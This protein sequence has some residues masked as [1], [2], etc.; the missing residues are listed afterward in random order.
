[1]FAKASQVVPDYRQRKNPTR[2]STLSSQQPQRNPGSILLKT[3]NQNVS[4]SS[5]NNQNQLD[6]YKTAT[7]QTH[8]FSSWSYTSDREQ[9]QQQVESLLE[10]RG[11]H[12][13][14]PIGGTNNHLVLI[15]DDL[16]LPD[17][18]EFSTSSALSFLRQLISLKSL[19]DKERLLREIS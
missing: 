17:V 7:T 8:W 19:Y 6:C 12:S 18:D 3:A 1:M 14:G 13:L 2:Q 9:A 10:R 11:P 15:V 4:S 5:N 16:N